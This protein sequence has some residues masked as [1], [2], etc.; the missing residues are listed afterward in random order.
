MALLPLADG[1]CSIVWS[2]FE[3]EARELLA[4]ADEEFGARLTAATGHVLGTLLPTTLRVALPLA[5]LHARRYT[6]ARFALIGDAAHQIHPLAGQGINLGLLDARALAEV[7]AGQL[8]GTRLADP[9]DARLLRRYERSRKGAN[10]L[11]LAAMEGLHRVFTAPSPAL[12]KLAAA[13]LGAVDR[14]PALKRMFMN[15]AAGKP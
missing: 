2:C 7:L 6:G 4:L 10:L 5:A 14:F 1:R 8:V 12:T 13:G 15:Q 3:P 9:G 11:T